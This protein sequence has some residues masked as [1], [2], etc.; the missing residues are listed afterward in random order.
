MNHWNLVLNLNQRQR[1]AHRFADVCCACVVAPR[2]IT[3]KQRMAG[4][5]GVEAVAAS[6]AT[7]T[8][9]SYAPGTRTT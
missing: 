6:F 8:G 4:E 9:I 2:K 3:P 1:I 5:N 7:T